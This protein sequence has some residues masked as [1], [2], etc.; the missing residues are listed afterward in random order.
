MLKADPDPEV[1]KER[2]IDLRKKVKRDIYSWT[3]S[4]VNENQ[5]QP[6]KQE[7][8]DVAGNLFKAYV[9]VSTFYLD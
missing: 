8:K 2:M 3:K 9:A 7:R 5:R 6:T 1:Y 4:F